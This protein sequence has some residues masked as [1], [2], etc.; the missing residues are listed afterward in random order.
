[1]V[2]KASDEDLLISTKARMLLASKKKIHERVSK[3][4]MARRGRRLLFGI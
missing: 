4:G 3:I 1:M 2:G